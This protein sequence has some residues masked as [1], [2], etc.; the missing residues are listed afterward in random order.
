MPKFRL[1][2]S[3]VLQRPNLQTQKPDGTFTQT[4]TMLDLDTVI[5]KLKLPGKLPE[6]VYKLR[7][8]KPNDAAISPF[9]HRQI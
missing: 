5:L 7:I 6:L 8:F 1:R 9:A 3:L 4:S 2:E